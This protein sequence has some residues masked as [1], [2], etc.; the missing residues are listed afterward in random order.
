M[1]RICL[2]LLMVFG[3]L[4]VDAE[5]V[6]ISGTF[7][8]G[9]NGRVVLTDM[10]NKEVGVGEMSDGV[11]VIRCDI[12]LTSVRNHKLFIYPE[13][14]VSFV[15]GVA[16][17]TFF[18]DSPEIHVDVVHDSRGLR[19]SNIQGSSFTKEYNKLHEGLQCV[20]SRKKIQEEY[21]LLSER[22]KSL[23]QKLDAGG[24]EMKDELLSMCDKYN[25]NEVYVTLLANSCEEFLNSKEIDEWCERLDTG[26]KDNYYV[27]KLIDKST[28]EKQN[29]IGGEAYEFE[30]VDT[31]GVK[32]KLTDFRG[33]YVLLDFWASWCG[34][35][36]SE[37]PN[38]E[39]AF[40]K[41]KDCGLVV[42]G[43]SSDRKKEAW[44]KAVREEKTSYLQL[45]GT[46]EC[47]IAYDFKYI[48]Y[49]ILLDPNGKI[50]AKK[51]RGKDIE[52][53]IGKYLKPWK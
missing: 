12:D 6:K 29:R 7:K 23:K 2:L 28:R 51:L 47:S 9:G 37:I 17:V 13:K 24:V 18:I 46:V 4:G 52:E 45:L 14:K 16:C 44:L 10:E 31:S 42:I 11:F 1:K 20:K 33:K 3:I 26:V 49:I 25:N 32:H 27:K 36:R 40:L 5:S 35:C 53:T 43:I 34:P 8:D 50:I 39:K 21:E 22:V 38:I 19:I 48:P 41:Y 15:L 30:L